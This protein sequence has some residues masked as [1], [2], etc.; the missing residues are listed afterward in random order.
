M[1]RNVL[2]AAGLLVI[3][4]ILAEVGS[5]VFFGLGSPPLVYANTKFGYA[6]RPNQSLKRF[7]HP[8]SYNEQGLRSEPLRPTTGTAYRILCVGGSVTNGGALVDQADTYPYQLERILSAKGDKA[9][10]LNASAV[11]WTLMNEYS[12]LE[13]K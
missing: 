8:I 6:F 12:F 1:K 4:L 9:Q 11:G 10:V 2:I 5:R 3:L 13:D 7:G